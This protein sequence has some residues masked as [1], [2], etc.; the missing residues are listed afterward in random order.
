MEDE[1]Q[2]GEETAKTKKE[3]V[4]DRNATKTV[5]KVVSGVIWTIGFAF[6]IALLLPHPLLANLIAL[7]TFIAVLYFINLHIPQRIRRRKSSRR[8][9][10]IT[11][12][13]L[14]I[15]ASGATLAH[16]WITRSSLRVSEAVVSKVTTPD[17][18]QSDQLNGKAPEV[19]APHLD[20]P[21][22]NQSQKAQGHSKTEKGTDNKSDNGELGISIEGPSR[23]PIVSEKWIDP[24]NGWAEGVVKYAD[25]D[26]AMPNVPIVIESPK[27]NERYQT[28]SDAK[29]YFKQQLPFGKYK[30]TV[31]QDGYDT[32]SRPC[33]I[34]KRHG[35][36]LNFDLSFQDITKI[37]SSMDGF[38]YDNE[39]GNPIQGATIKA[40][41]L[42]TKEIYSAASGRDGRFVATLPFGEY[43]LT[44]ERDGYITVSNS[45]H[46]RRAEGCFAEFRLNK[47]PPKSN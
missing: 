42:V 16:L 11:Y 18:H 43:K 35:C 15:I 33:Q 10:R 8:K 46:A 41:H 3:Q 6:C 23:V 37:Q 2:S 30:V 45:C 28:V 12:A 21:N 40:T 32:I 17:V 29:G 14:I 19:L 20:P 36:Y 24:E 44:A 13:S 39:T 38:V 25:S 34:G 47:P 5:K 1:T 26:Q 27:T 9:I 4:H 7:P 22:K 31:S